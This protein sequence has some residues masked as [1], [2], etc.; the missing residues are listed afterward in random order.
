MMDLRHTFKKRDYIRARGSSLFFADNGPNAGLR[1]RASDSNT[2]TFI[3]DSFD[4]GLIASDIDRNMGYLAPLDEAILDSYNFLQLEKSHFMLNGVEDYAG[5]NPYQSAGL[6][7]KLTTNVYST[8][9]DLSDTIMQTKIINP[10]VRKY[11]TR[12][13]VFAT[14][15]VRQIEILDTI[16]KSR[17]TNRP[18]ADL[19][20]GNLGGTPVPVAT[21]YITKSGLVIP[22]IEMNLE[23]PAGTA[24]LYDPTLIK[25]KYL[26]LGSFGAGP[27]PYLI[28]E[29]KDGFAKVY[30]M[31]ETFCPEIQGEERM[32]KCTG[33]TDD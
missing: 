21:E 4:V 17:T 7:A 31:F 18:I 25:E 19:Q 2:I 8:G 33:L 10:I 26:Q 24:V 12:R 29:V 14:K 20:F 11:G 23:L 27:G 1:K 15:S 32:C 30:Y 9:G 6:L 3:G 22:V 28:M 16:R 13:W 5:V